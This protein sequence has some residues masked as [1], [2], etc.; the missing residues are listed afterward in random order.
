MKFS[1]QSAYSAVAA[2]TALFG[3][4]QANEDCYEN[5]PWKSHSVGYDTGGPFCATRWKQGG[6]I[7]GVQA[8]YNGDSINGIEF[9][10]TDGAAPERFGQ[11]YGDKK[12]WLQWDTTKEEVEAI[13][14][15]PNGRSDVERVA[16]IQITI[17]GREPWMAGNVPKKT[18]GYDS[19]V[20]NGAGIIMGAFG[21]HGGSIDFL[22]F[23]MLESGI[24]DRNIQDFNLNCDSLNANNEAIKNAKPEG[25]DSFTQENWTGNNMTYQVTRSTRKFKSW[26]TTRNSAKTFGGSVSAGI[27]FGLPAI[28]LGGSI[29]TEF[30]WETKTETETNES[31]ELEVSTL[32]V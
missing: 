29:N 19:P 1:R 3:T 12:D 10:Y 25:I 24:K 20:V 15:W 30:H 14:I 22:G 26:S 23:M 13:T 18:Q 17:R 7:N 2:V 9:Q 27:D 28:G 8:W 21:K 11:M 5:G 6:A 4:A 31:G 32:S 16:A